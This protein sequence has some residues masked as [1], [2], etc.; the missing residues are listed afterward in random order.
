MQKD[1]IFG[2]IW[3]E[4][5]AFFFSRLA[6]LVVV[7]QG[8]EGTPSPPFPPTKLFPKSYS[9]VGGQAGNSMRFLK[10]RFRKVRSQGD[11]W[12]RG[13][14]GTEVTFCIVT[15]KRGSCQRS[16]HGIGPAA[17]F[18]WQTLSGHWASVSI[19]GLRFKS[20]NI[21]EKYYYF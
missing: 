18:R 8:V 14:G 17:E 11:R 13:G 10:G 20:G 16:I 9:P 3:S 15:F 7:R 6:I 5:A 12:T 19:Q 1:T 21:I 2:W 4:H